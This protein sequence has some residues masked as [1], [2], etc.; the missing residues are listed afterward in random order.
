MKKYLNLF[1]VSI[2]MIFLS[3]NLNF[4]QNLS[5][6]SWG[7]SAAVNNS[8]ADLLFPIWLGNSS[9]IAPGIGVFGLS[10]IYTDLS[11]GLVYR[12]YFKSNSNFSPIIGAR[13]GAIIGIPKTGE[14]TTDWVAGILGGGEYFFSGN[15]SVGIE[16]QFNLAF[17][18]K[19]ST[20]FGNPDGTSFNTGS[21]IFATVYF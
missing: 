9:T 16:A 3:A 20:R 19:F 8:Q 12:Y 11:A 15:F 14:G 7:I 17:S 6:G 13:A 4:A 1:M 18:D 21:V 5:H 10:D 2:L